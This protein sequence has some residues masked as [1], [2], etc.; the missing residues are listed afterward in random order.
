[1][2]S[3]RLALALS[4]ADALP[5]EGRV[6]AVGAR[7]GLADLPKV[8][9]VVVQ[10]FRPDHDA[11][12]A[13]GWAVVPDLAGA[14]GDFAAAVVFLPRSR[15]AAH[16]AVAEVAARVRP[17]GPVWVDGQKTD[18]IDAM[19]KDL[20]AR[21]AVSAPLAKAHGKIFRFAAG[22]DLAGWRAAD[23]HPAPGFVTRPG[24][25]SAE[26][27]DPGSAL[28]A[29]ALPARLP[30]LVAD[31]GAGWGWLG[32]QVLGRSGVGEL[33]LVEA[34]HASLAC[35]RRNVTDPRVRFHW[36]D[37]IRFRPEAPFDA[38][39]MNPPFHSGRAADPS[40]G[41]AFIAAAAAMLAPAGRLWM[42]ANRHLPYEP[43][44]AQHFREVT[45]I[46]GDGAFK[47]FLAARPV[48]RPL[49]AVRTAPRPRG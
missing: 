42:V 1:M 23:L 8:R 32:A 30:A 31:L 17:G 5:A 13:E 11:L 2:A 19:L 41:A 45:A 43:V 39:V 44:L 46:G 21:T 24:V 36:A 27:V 3:S 15:A 28:L 6:L 25:F 38:V 35:A 10:G 49:P 48:A 9:T 16:D 12:A 33:H 18:G 26:K 37:A 14:T 40:L 7:A 34:D 47:L 22:A 20:R 29:A 4:G